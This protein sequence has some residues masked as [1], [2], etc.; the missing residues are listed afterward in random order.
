[1]KQYFLGI[2]QP[3]GGT[4]PDNLDE[5]MADL[6]AL[7]EEMRAA[8]AWVFSAGL[9]APSTATVVQARPGGEVLITDGP[10]VESKEYL[11]GFSI[12]AAEDL[13]AALIWVRRLATVIGLPIE[14]R[15]L[16]GDE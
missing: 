10:Y 9:H 11:A 1:M 16:V 6:D 3:E 8:G 14:V 12:I 5:I 4:P 2:Q 13:D 15:P 7:N